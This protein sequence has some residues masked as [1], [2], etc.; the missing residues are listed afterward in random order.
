MDPEVLNRL[1][2]VATRFRLDEGEQRVVSL[3]LSPTPDG[4]I[5]AY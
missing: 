1:R 4:L 3:T 5:P 2:P